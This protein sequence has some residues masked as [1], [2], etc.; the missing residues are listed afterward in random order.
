[1]VFHKPTELG[2]DR[3]GITEDSAELDG[4][5]RGLKQDECYGEQDQDNIRKNRA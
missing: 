4:K 1:M 2:K 5:A 3:L